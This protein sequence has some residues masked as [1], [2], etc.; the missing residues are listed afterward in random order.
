MFMFQPPQNGTA[1][2]LSA[3]TGTETTSGFMLFLSL[4]VSAGLLVQNICI[5]QMQ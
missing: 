2:A 4:T 1:G 3:H 5:A